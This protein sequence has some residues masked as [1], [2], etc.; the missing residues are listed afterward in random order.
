MLEDLWQH[1]TR[2]QRRAETGR[3]LAESYCTTSPAASL[4]CAAQESHHNRAITAEGTARSLAHSLLALEGWA[5]I[6]RDCASR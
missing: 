4:A 3:L 6:T 2:L 5:V 1:V